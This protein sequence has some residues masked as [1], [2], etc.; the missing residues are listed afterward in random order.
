MCSARLTA[1]GGLA[2]LVRDPADVPEHHRAHALLHRG[3]GGPFR[4]DR[5]DGVDERRGVHQAQRLAQ[6]SAPHADGRVGEEEL[7]E[8]ALEPGRQIARGPAQPH[9]LGDLGHHLLDIGARVLRRPVARVLGVAH[10]RFPLSP[11]QAIA[12]ESRLLSDEMRAACT[13]MRTAPVTLL[14]FMTSK[15]PAFSCQS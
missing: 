12:A 8:L 5:H 7:V 15:V 10:A 6:V 14:G 13:S 4:L 9:L 11:F 1:D 2:H 3:A